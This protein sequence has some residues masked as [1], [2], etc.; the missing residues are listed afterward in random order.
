MAPLNPTPVIFTED[1]AQTTETEGV[2]AHTEYAFTNE[3]KVI[4]GIRETHEDVDYTYASGVNVNFPPQYELTPV[5]YDHATL[6]SNGV[7]GKIGLNYQPEQ[8]RARL[9]EPQ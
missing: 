3:W 5:P 7:S 9:S 8:G 4:A 1:I 6:S 2:F